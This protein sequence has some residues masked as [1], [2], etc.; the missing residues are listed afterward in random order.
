MDAT[1]DVASDAGDAATTGCSAGPRTIVDPTQAPDLVPAGDVGSTLGIF[2]PSIVYP[3]GAPGGVLAYSSVPSQDA[4]VTRIA[5][6]NDRG[7]TWLTVKDANATE[8]VTITDATWC[9]AATCAGRIIREVPSLIYD[10]DDVASARFKVYTHDYIAKP[11]SMPVVLKYDW[12]TIGV[13]TAPDPSGPWSAT[14]KVLGWKSSQPAISETGASQLLT[15]IPALADCIAFS[16]PGALYRSG[17]I[18]LAL[19]CVTAAPEIRVELLR[20]TDHG[21][22]FSYVTRLLD[23]RDATC[24]GG[25][26]PQLNAAD[27]FVAGGKQFLI[28]TTAGPTAGLPTGYNGCSVLAI[29]DPSSGKVR[30]DDAGA[31]VVLRRIVSPGGSPNGRFI[32]ACAYAEGAS[33][34]GYI[35]PELFVDG[36]PRVFRFFRSG[37]VAP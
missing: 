30:R 24:L 4:I 17:A 10:P 3:L 22:T 26:A 37:I 1:A 9:G 11:G 29:D 27:L 8:D 25:A 14:K 12:G 6:S 19:G 13:V 32:G 35:V 36:P 18:D 28:V 31:P 33:G 34:A 21:A 15:D 20:S 5:V 16:E 7:V 2:D 23:A